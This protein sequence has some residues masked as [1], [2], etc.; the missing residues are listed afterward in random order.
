MSTNCSECKGLCCIAYAF[1]EW[2]KWI[3]WIKRQWERCQY[4]T[5]EFRCAVENTLKPWFSVCVNYDCHGIWNEICKQHPDANLE[6]LWLTLWI[7][8]L[9]RNF[10]QSR[11]GNSNLP[12]DEWVSIDLLSSFKF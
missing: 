1:E 10:M 2:E 11:W 5:E 8:L 12:W 7:S 3:P 6:D 9:T 4:L